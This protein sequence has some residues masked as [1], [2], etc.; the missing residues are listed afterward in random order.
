[1]SIY[2][3]PHKSHGATPVPL[4]EVELGVHECFEGHRFSLMQN[5]DGQYLQGTS[6]VDVFEAEIFDVALLGKF[7][8]PVAPEKEK[9]QQPETESAPISEKRGSFDKPAVAVVPKYEEKDIPTVRTDKSED[10]YEGLLNPGA[11]NSKVIPDVIHSET[12]AKDD[13]SAVAPEK[14][15]FSLKP[16][17]DLLARWNDSEVDK[18]DK[19]LKLSVY[20]CPN[21][22]HG[23]EPKPLKTM[24]G[25]IYF[26]I[27]QHRFTMEIENGKKYFKGVGQT[28]LYESVI[29]TGAVDNSQLEGG[30]L[31]HNPDEV[32]LKAEEKEEEIDDFSTSVLYVCPNSIHGKKKTP[33]SYED[34]FHICF[35]GHKYKLKVKDG[36][37]GLWSGDEEKLF[38]AETYDISLLQNYDE[39]EFKAEELSEVTIEV[40]DFID[41][42]SSTKNKLPDFLKKTEPVPE[43]S[44]QDI[45]MTGTLQNNSVL[46]ESI[47][48]SEDEDS[49][50][51]ESIEH[52]VPLVMNELNFNELD[53]S[54][55]EWKFVAKSDGYENLENIFLACGFS[56]EK[57]RKIAKSLLERKIIKMSDSKY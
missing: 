32:V 25:V 10:K 38:K 49:F 46:T 55:E 4:N 5:E 16:N 37:K 48:S 11:G 22:S 50:D 44:N 28:A 57:G 51:R 8:P 31:I 40:E 12:K 14:E 17:E 21:I 41:E 30:N 1:M 42:P 56:E 35:W 2:R 45:D 18:T 15:S 6:E 36:V 9:S 29:Y 24:D 52:F 23:S 54:P 3:C 43:V 13:N 33:L 19:A 7:K 53:L 20:E 39:A 34:G 26:C 27:D 47:A